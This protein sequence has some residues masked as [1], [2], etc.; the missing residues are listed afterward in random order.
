MGRSSI[1]SAMT[2]QWEILRRIPLCPPGITSAQLTEFLREERGFKVSRRT[3]DRDLTQ[4]A[5]PFGIRCND[6]AVPHGWYWV[7]GKRP[8]FGDLDL[9]EALSLVLAEGALRR[10]LPLNLLPSIEQ[11]LSAAHQKLSS[12]AGHPFTRWSERLRSVS[13]TLQTLSPSLNT[14]AFA[15]LQEALMHGKQVAAGYLGFANKR[16]NEMVLHPLGLVH[17]GAVIYL[18]ATA[19]EYTD[20]RLYA[21]HRLRS[22]KVIPEDSRTPNNFDL[23]RHIDSGALHFGSDQKFTLKARLDHDLAIHLEESPLS[24]DQRIKLVRG[25][26]LLTATMTDTWQLHWWILSQGSAIEVVSPKRLRRKVA[27]SLREA[28]EVY[29]RS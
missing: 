4:L 17:R 24:Q 20:V 18:V 14:H 10:L 2:R 26:Y 16:T 25:A 22:V 15:A 6:E 13:A 1:H 29:G 11:K 19:F 5:G 21:V 7:K 23:D 12:A 8:E 28:A 3:V 27:E 9:G